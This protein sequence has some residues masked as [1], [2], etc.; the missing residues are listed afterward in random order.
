MSHPARIILSTDNLL[1]NLSVIKFLAPKSRLMAV[2]KANA[3]GHGLEYV[4]TR[5]S[6]YADLFAVSSINE[7]IIIR[8]ANVKNPV[9]L[10][11]GVFNKEELIL[12]EKYDFQP[13][14]HNFEQIEYLDNCSEEI[15]LESWFKIDSGMNR[16]GF[17]RNERKKA[18][19]KLIASDKI[20]KPINIMSHFACADDYNHHL[21]IT[22]INDFL[23]FKREISPYIKVNNNISKF[24]LCNSAAIL[25][26]P[27]MHF[28]YIRPGLMLYG[29][30]PFQSNQ[31]MVQ[32][33]NVLDQI[34]KIKPV[35]KLKTKLISVKNISAG[36]YIG[37]SASYQCKKNMK[38][39]IVAFGYGDGYPFLSNEYTEI[40]KAKAVVMIKGV[41]CP[42]IGRVAMDMIT[43]DLTPCPLAQN[44]D[45]VILWGE[46]L[47]IEEVAARSN[48]IPWKLLTS[49]QK[50]VQYI[51]E[52]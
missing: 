34:A 16:L 47:K 25:N 37:Y 42:V 1:H 15:L 39:G 7:A 43:V 38:I 3:Y 52:D 13:V 12:C 4:A 35:M 28:D 5:I 29:V 33:M 18:F 8:E 19:D 49:M 50:R 21:N 44:G 14:F 41:K 32:N 36:S 30:S 10:L 22:Q 6:S 9:V 20:K 24:S 17:D 40:D 2:L 23:E 27:Q 11:E 31:N 51:W 26:F 45:D 46:E 48:N